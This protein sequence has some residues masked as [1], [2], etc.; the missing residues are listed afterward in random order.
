MLEEMTSTKEEKNEKEY[1]GKS[2]WYNKKTKT[3]TIEQGGMNSPTK[4]PN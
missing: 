4:P 1:K 3:K 2:P